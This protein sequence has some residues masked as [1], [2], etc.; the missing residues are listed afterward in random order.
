[1]PG[2][3]SGRGVK[4]LMDVANNVFSPDD[5]IRLHIVRA[6]PRKGGNQNQELCFGVRSFGLFQKY[7]R[8]GERLVDEMPALVHVLFRGT[9]VLC[10]FGTG[11]RSIPPIRAVR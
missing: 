4:R 9:D 7:S 3:E 6:I 1:M 5:V 2:R 10:G 11:W 8:S